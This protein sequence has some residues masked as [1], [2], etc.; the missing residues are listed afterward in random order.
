MLNEL[1][2][3]LRLWKIGYPLIPIKQESLDLY[4]RAVKN[5]ADESDFLARCK[6]SRNWHCSTKEKVIGNVT[7]RY[8]GNLA[9]GMRDGVIAKIHNKEGVY[10]LHRDNDIKQ[11]IDEIIEPISMKEVA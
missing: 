10:S 3:K 9:I 2:I 7:W 4:K 5:N 11:K 6:L 1:L 8:Y